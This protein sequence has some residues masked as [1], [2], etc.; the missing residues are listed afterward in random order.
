MVRKNASIFELI[1]DNWG[2]VTAL[3]VVVSQILAVSIEVQTLGFF[4]VEYLAIAQLSDIPL[5]LLRYPEMI[6]F[7]I[8]AGLA[9]YGLHNICEAWRTG[10]RTKRYFR[11]PDFLSNMLLI[12]LGAIFVLSFWEYSKSAQRLQW[13]NHRAFPNAV[14]ITATNKE[15]SKC[16]GYISATTTHLVL[17]DFAIKEAK[18]ILKSSVEDIRWPYGKVLESEGEHCIT[19]DS[20]EDFKSKE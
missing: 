12:V 1:K 17:Y 7:T 10:S 13:L 4:G 6:L 3:G 19:Y 8:Y 20:L 2:I 16:Y 14:M 11:T 15:K 18:T 9:I 5:I